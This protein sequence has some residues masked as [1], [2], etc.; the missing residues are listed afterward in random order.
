MSYILLELNNGQLLERYVEQLH[1]ESWLSD[2]ILA[3]EPLSLRRCLL[4]AGQ[5]QEFGKTYGDG[6]RSLEVCSHDKE[7]YGDYMRTKGAV[8]SLVIT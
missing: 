6:T 2:F 4:I 7:C 8:P 5:K 1:I 3:A